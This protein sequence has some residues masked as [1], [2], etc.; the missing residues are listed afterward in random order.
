MPMWKQ[1]HKVCIV[2]AENNEEEQSGSIWCLGEMEVMDSP[3]GNQQVKI[4]TVL[5]R[6]LLGGRGVGGFGHGCSAGP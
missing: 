1:S 5:K 6:T 4:V 2:R 3:V